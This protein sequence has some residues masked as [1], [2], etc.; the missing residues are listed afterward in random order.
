MYRKALV[1]GKFLYFVHAPPQTELDNKPERKRPEPPDP[2]EPKLYASVY[3]YWWAFLRL[4][5]DY[6]ACCER[7]GKGKMAAV[8]E[9]F[10]DVRDGRRKST[11]PG[12]LKGSV[13][14]FREWWIERG[15]Y[16][17]AEPQTDEFIRIVDG[18]PKAA[19]IEGRILLSI[20][21]A[22]NID[23]TTHTVGQMLR[24]LFRDYQKANGHYSQAR[25]KPKDNYRLS[26]LNQTLKIAHAELNFRKVGKI[27]KQWQLADKAEVP[28][29]VKDED[30]DVSAI[31]AKIV[32]LALNRAT[33][34]I[35]NAGRGSF[36][37]FSNP[38]PGDFVFYKTRPR[39]PRKKK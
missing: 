14:E 38:R 15:A 2:K 20:P 24:P 37:D 19:D 21:L 25:Y 29:Q 26:V 23:V 36:P 4:N 1:G 16:L 39:T 10:G 6:I 28:V 17:F 18:R 11:V 5:A 7:G 33:R 9:D 32:S 30:E 3:Y 13:D 27:Y 8:Y 12:Q 34:L 31:K 22:G 35:A